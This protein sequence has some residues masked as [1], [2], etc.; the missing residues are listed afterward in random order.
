MAVCNPGDLPALL[1]PRARVLGLDVGS[2]TIGLALSDFRLQIAS[3]LGTIR[4]VNFRGDMA[5]LAALIAE[6]SVGGF[7]VGLPLRLNGRDG[8]RTQSVRQFARNVVAACDRPLTFWDERLSTL[9]VERD[10]VAADLTRQRR[11]AIVDR[12]AAAYILQGYLD[13]LNRQPPKTPC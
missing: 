9:A 5:A 3:P 2:K 6:R 7:L 12:V 13:W 11:A 1:P 10:M 8:P 4:R